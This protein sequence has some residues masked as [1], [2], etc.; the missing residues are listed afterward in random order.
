MPGWSL[1]TY[2]RYLILVLLKLPTWHLLDVITSHLNLTRWSWQHPCV[3]HN[4]M[5]K[6]VC[7]PLTVFLLYPLNKFIFT[8][9]YS[10]SWL[11]HL[12]VFMLWH[13]FSANYF[14]VWPYNICFLLLFLHSGFYI[15]SFCIHAGFHLFSFCLHTVFDSSFFCQH[16]QYFQYWHPCFKHTKIYMVFIATD[17][18]K[19]FFFSCEN[20]KTS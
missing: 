18:I 14:R 3:R 9:S 7:A 17:S 8:S 2:L 15:F 11:W 16:S 6:S 12:S 4:G 19:I 10:Y 13:L 1:F 5:M 20:S